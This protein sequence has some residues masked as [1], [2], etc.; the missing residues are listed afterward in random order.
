[1]EWYDRPVVEHTEDDRN[2][3]TGKK[4]RRSRQRSHLSLLLPGAPSGNGKHGARFLLTD[5]AIASI[6]NE[7]EHGVYPQQAAKALGISPRTFASYVEVARAFEAGVM[8]SD[9]YF[10]PYVPGRKDL[11]LRLLHQVRE[12]SGK[13]RSLA[14]RRVY[15]DKPEFW[16]RVGPGRDK[17]EIEPG[18]TERTVIG[19]EG[20]APIRIKPEYVD[21][22][23]S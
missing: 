9:N 21:V 14:E 8:P 3:R 6:A 22:C 13:A 10:N 12:A 17:G 2:S 15:V 23:R 7:V 16:L 11:L 19:G 1:M 5:E 20:G 4:R 18:W